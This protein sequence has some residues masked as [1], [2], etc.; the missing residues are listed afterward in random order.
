MEAQKPLLS[1]A[2]PSQPNGH[3]HATTAGH[4]GSR[5]SETESFIRFLEMLAHELM[6]PPWALRCIIAVVII[7]YTPF[8]LIH[9]F[10]ALEKILLV[11]RNLR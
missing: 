6:P 10:T 8:V 1:D 9:W 4:A 5:L 3:D 2:L 11:Y 7:Y